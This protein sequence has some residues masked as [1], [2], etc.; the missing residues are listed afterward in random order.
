MN[1]SETAVARIQKF[2]IPKFKKTAE[3]K[4]KFEYVPLPFQSQKLDELP[5]YKVLEGIDLETK[6]ERAKDQIPSCRTDMQCYFDVL[7]TCLFLEENEHMKPLKNSYI[8][9]INIKLSGEIATFHVPV[10]IL[11]FYDIFDLSSI[12]NFIVV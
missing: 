8:K 5:R 10:S 1:G 2:R 3:P 11:V 9:N 12:C 6:Y 7:S 4:A